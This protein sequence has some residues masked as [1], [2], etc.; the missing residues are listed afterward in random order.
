MVYCRPCWLRSEGWWGDGEPNGVPLTFL[1][2]ALAHLHHKSL[3]LVLLQV[4]QALPE[5]LSVFIFLCIAAYLHSCL[6]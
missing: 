5:S 2:T 4:K 6:R 1:S 3:L